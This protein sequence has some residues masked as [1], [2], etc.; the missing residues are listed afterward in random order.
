MRVGQ[1]GEIWEQQ[2]D[3]DPGPE[4]RA[5]RAR[6]RRVA[7]GRSARRGPTVEPDQA[8]TAAMRN[9][10]RQGRPGRQQG[11]PRQAIAA[12]RAPDR[13]RHERGRGPAPVT[14]T[15]A[16]AGTTT[17]R[18]ESNRLSPASPAAPC[19]ARTQ[20]CGWRSFDFWVLAASAFLGRRLRADD[21]ALTVSQ[22][23]FEFSRRAIIRN[24]VMALSAFQA[25]R[26]IQRESAMET[27]SQRPNPPSGPQ[28]GPQTRGAGDLCRP[29][30]PA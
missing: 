19:Y 27:Q 6:A 5:G 21:A 10:R 16:T 26:P 14:R 28:P 15:A 17:H 24:R 9:E 8:Q 11:D 12:T 22:N 30:R 29:R 4:A 13:G 3:R 2:E 25:Q 20:S 7:D 1:E 23:T 18:S